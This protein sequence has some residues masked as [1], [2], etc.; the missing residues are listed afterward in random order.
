LGVTPYSIRHFIAAATNA[1]TLSAAVGLQPTAGSWRK[2]IIER[3]RR[4][5]GALSQSVATAVQSTLKDMYGC[6]AQQFKQERRLC[7]IHTYLHSREL[8][9]KFSS[10]LPSLI[11]PIEGR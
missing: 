11:T 8:S 6:L 3:R 2:S 9:S 4:R 10:K 7:Q 1:P 5:H